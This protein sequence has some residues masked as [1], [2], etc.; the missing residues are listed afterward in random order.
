MGFTT[1]ET[2]FDAFFAK[3]DD[4][5]LADPGGNT[6]RIRA[7]FRGQGAP[8]ATEIP[9]LAVQILSFNRSGIVDGNNRWKV[10]IKLRVCYTASIDG[11]LDDAL[12]YSAQLDNLLD[13]WLP[14]TGLEGGEKTT[15]SPTLPENTHEGADAI[16][17]GETFI[18]I[19]SS[20]GAN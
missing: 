9:F 3:V 16:V 20:R 10:R 11:A 8:T 2:G 7:V 4:V 19:I 18:E 1:L 5:L 14:T 17:E 12:R 6:D 13:G 15:W